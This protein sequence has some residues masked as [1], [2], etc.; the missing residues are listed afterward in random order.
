[1]KPFSTSAFKVLTCIF[2]ST[3]QIFTSGRSAPAYAVNYSATTTPTYSLK[4]RIC[5]N[6]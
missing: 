4:L 6:G 3:T 5:F 2:A 1:M